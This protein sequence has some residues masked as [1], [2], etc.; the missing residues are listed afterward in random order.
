MIDM[1]QRR[2]TE[3]DYLTLFPL[4]RPIEIKA[5]FENWRIVA[6]PC[7]NF[8]GALFEKRNNRGK[9]LLDGG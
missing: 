1:K 7:R 8:R 2:L 9:A 3:Y 4:V 6:H 5:E